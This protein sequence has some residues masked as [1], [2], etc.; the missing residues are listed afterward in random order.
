VGDGEFQRKCLR[1]M[2]DLHNTGR[3]VLFESHNLTAVENLCSRAIWIDAGRV[4]EDGPPSQVIQSYMGTF[5]SAGDTARDLRDI[6]GRQGSGEI[7]FT[8]IEFLSQDRDLAA[9]IR[10]GDP[11]AV[12]LHFEAAREV[13]TPIFGIDVHTAF[14]TLVAQ[15]HTYNDDFTIPALPAG[16]GYIDVRIESLNLV[17]GQYLLSLYAANLGHVYHDV[18]EHCTAID[19]QASTRYGLMRGMKNPIVALESRWELGQAG[20]H[21]VSAGTRG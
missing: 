4:R 6:E 17:P 11:V 3:T 8:Q 7:R 10:C 14:G 19:V 15:V 13:G 21:A 1:A 18:L 9:S 16:P 20:H 2:G 12:R 5:A